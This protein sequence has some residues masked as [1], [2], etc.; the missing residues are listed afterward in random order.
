VS[1]LKYWPTQ[2]NC[3]ACIKPEAEN[4][5]DA[6]FLAVHQEMRFVKKSFATQQTEKKTQKQLLN[7]FLRDDPSGRVILPIL[8]ESGIGKSHLVRWL[9][10]QLRQ[11]KDKERRL[12]IRIPKSSSLKSVLG[13]ILDELKGPKYERIRSQLQSAREEMDEI[14]AKQAIRGGLLAAIERKYETAYRRKVKARTNGDNLSQQDELWIGHGDARA[15]PALLDDPATQKLF[16]QG[17]P[18][19]PG[20]ISELVRHVT[21]DTSVNDAPRRQFER[22]DFLVPAELAD[23]VK[24]AGQ[25]AGKYLQR[26]GRE[27]TKSLDDAIGL[28]N[29]IV[30]DAI[31]P[32]ATPTDTSLAELFYEVRR[33]LLAEGRELVILVED[34][35]VL[36][37]VQKA[38]LDAIIREGESSGKT[39]ACVIR[40]ALAV[41][42][43]YFGNLDTVESRAVHG[44]Y[45]HSI[46]EESD[47]KVVDRIGNFVAAYV[48]AARIGPQNLE[49]YYADSANTTKPVP[50]ALEYIEPENDDLEMLAAF[51]KS[52]DN[53]SLFPFNQSA[54]RE[55]ADW[56]LRDTEGRLRFHPRSIINE[57]I[58][59]VVKDYRADFEQKAFP[60]DQ[61]L[62][63][64]PTQI[65]AD[66]QTEV[67]Q[68]ESDRER[69]RQYLYLYRFWGN[70]PHKISD[71]K[72][73]AK[74]YE[75][76]GLEVLDENAESIKPPPSLA[77]TSVEK[78][79]TKSRGSRTTPV[80]T[81]ETQEPK[82]VQ[83]F[84]EKLDAWRGGGILGQ[85]DA[86]RIRKWMNEHLMYSINWEAELLRQIK[87]ATD[88]FAN[89]IYLPR[90]KGNKSDLDKA[91]IV[92]AED[93][94]FGETD[95][96]NAI[97][98]AVRAMLRYD[99][100]GNWDF[101]TADSDY[102][103]IANFVDRHLE[104][105]ID[106]IRSHYKM[107]EGDPVPALTQ[108]LLWQA[109]LL[110]VE[111]AHR[112]DDPS[113]LAA[114]FQSDLP[115]LHRDDD[116]D[117]NV[118]LEEMASQREYLRIE[119]LERT[120]AWQ[121]TTGKTPYAVDA[122]QILDSVHEL[123]KTWI[124]T[125]GFPTPPTSAPDELKR[126]NEHIN[127]LARSGASKVEKR[128]KRI[129]NQS[130]LIV[131]EL[132]KDYDKNQLVS[133]LEEVCALTQQHGLMGEVTVP[134]IKKLL[135]EFKQARAK[136]VGKQ[137][138]QIVNNQDLG[139]QMSA[140][141]TLDIQT[142]E[143]LA[144]FCEW[145]AKFLKERLGKAKSQII[146]WT[147]EVVE[148]KKS[149]V[150]AILADM[151]T[152]AKPF[153]G[154]HQ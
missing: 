21:K 99:H 142:L 90:A 96:A 3:L 41:T 72:I 44:W 47:D 68:K 38:L 131:E 66:L 71:A 32:L 101:K 129:A 147:Q 22:E 7:E 100:Y 14:G 9:D 92:V 86:I 149:E 58:L 141:A 1:L 107:V 73:P 133:D 114:V 53:H 152:A 69:S 59:P 139:S 85:G 121:G 12:V 61:F 57:I 34:F 63:F 19:R 54:I 56:K 16:I 36:A 143:Q 75:A 84:L 24:E 130:Q 80:P 134:Q 97:Y 135:E 91:F 29:Q 118:F 64:S 148:S 60:P 87:P 48:N 117:W 77:G 5:S 136:E 15:L 20:I 49:E 98:F 106:W 67:G 122:T 93:Q 62:G 105:A 146:T 23:E 82:P 132:G 52:A 124:V 126:M 11:R 37:G 138:D 2:A 123:K 94:A 89:R 110:N 28:L 27:N 140:I 33:Q 18:S 128:R 31:E 4:P 119:I 42:D 40:T 111:S 153:S 17:T 55:L 108:A 145:C 46:E 125:T 116:E 113:L 102:A 25:I 51:G 154:D 6:V 115:E 150:D 74:V 26:L 112:A 81:S 103:A 30:D 76:F 104:S 137:V 151:E 83:E 45:L 109:R 10:V 13:R 95:V 35:A 88:T 78:P 144:R 8:G 65:D 50:Q 39:E 79:E 70:D 43:G 127:Q 120:A